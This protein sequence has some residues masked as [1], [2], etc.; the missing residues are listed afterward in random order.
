MLPFCKRF[1][2]K[3]TVLVMLL[4]VLACNSS[5]DGDDPIPE[6]A[7]SVF[8]VSGTLLGLDASRLIDLSN[9]FETITLSA[10]GTFEFGH[11]Y[12]KDEE[13]SVRIAIQPIGQTCTI[14]ND[15]GTISDSVTDVIIDC[16]GEALVTQIA[17]SSQHSCAVKNAGVVCWGNDTS[18]QATPPELINP[19]A[20]SA[21]LKHSCAITENGVICWGA[22]TAQQ[23]AVPDDLLLP[24]DLTSGDNHTCVIHQASLNQDSVNQDNEKST[25]ACWGDNSAGQLSASTEL[26]NPSAIAAGGDTTCV[27]DA[28]NVNCWGG[29]SAIVSGIPNTFTQPTKISVGFNHA[30]VIDSG[31]IVCWGDNT[32]GQLLVPEEISNPQSLSAG[33]DHTC[34]IDQNRL[35]CWGGNAS[36]QSDVP[37]QF[38]NATVVAAGKWY[39][40][41]AN[42]AGLTCWGFNNLDQADPPT[43]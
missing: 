43:D 40:C 34:A 24:S 26:T 8:T 5:D 11:Q 42:T 33:Y 23:L 28:S 1:G 13:Y 6:D 19:T 27:I 9:E 12:T 15:S 36:G 16:R 30:C 10:N 17:A 22:N 20:I 38:E 2:K 35:R 14:E 4:S 18:G 21:G 7:P 29:S 3:A 39:T 41:A 37:T 31:D 32:K 25:I